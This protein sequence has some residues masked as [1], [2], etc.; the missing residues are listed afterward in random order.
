MVVVLCS[1]P[2]DR[3]ADIAHDV[4]S[5]GLAAC[6]QRFD[7]RSVYQWE[8]AVHDEPETTLVMK[9]SADRVDALR[10]HLIAIHP[11]DLPEFVVLPVD[12]ARSHPL[13]VAWVR[14]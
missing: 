9:V 1:C 5:R 7:V 8:G 2:P 11:Y 12:E 3:A 10:T 14:D 13:Y 4:V 6:V